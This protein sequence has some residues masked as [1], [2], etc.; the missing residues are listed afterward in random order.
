LAARSTVATLD[1][2]AGIRSQIDTLPDAWD[3]NHDVTRTIGQLEA[4]SA[5]CAA[6]PSIQALLYGAA[7][8]I[9]D[10]EPAGRRLEKLS[11][12]LHGYVVGWEDGAAPR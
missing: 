7:R 4:L 2:L 1:E 12:H 3:A 10:G 11:D 5:T 6:Y 8:V 9:E